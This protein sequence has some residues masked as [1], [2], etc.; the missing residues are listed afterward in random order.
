MLSTLFPPTAGRGKVHDKHTV[1]EIAEIRSFSGICNQKNIYWKDFTVR[2]HLTYFAQLR[3]VPA[4]EVSS[5]IHDFALELK[6]IEHMDTKMHELSGGN[7]RKVALCTSIL[8]ASDVLFLD[9]PSAGVDP[10][11][12]DEMKNVLVKL[13]SGRTV[14]FTSHTM[15]EAEIMCDDVVIMVKGKMEAQGEVNELITRF[16]DGYTLQVDTSEITDVQV[17]EIKDRV[18]TLGDVEEHAATK[19]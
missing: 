4:E 17:Q 8:G 19:A 1:T 18:M 16:S 3:G 10:F 14:L 2:E 6:F 15:E 9:E 12:R 11:A 5:L 7:K 13:K